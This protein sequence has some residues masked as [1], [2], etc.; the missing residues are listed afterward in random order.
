M[1][2]LSAHEAFCDALE[3]HVDFPA[4]QEVERRLYQL[5]GAV[6]NLTSKLPRHL[7]HC[8]RDAIGNELEADQW[9]YSGH[10]YAGAA[11]RIRPTLKT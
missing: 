2:E 3:S 4:D 8:A 6:W 11:R 1:T 10:T 7:W 5:C 9:E